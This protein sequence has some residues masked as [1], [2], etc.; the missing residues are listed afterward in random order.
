M[1]NSP[2]RAR[3]DSCT[4]S[5]T[6]HHSP[7]PK[8]TMSTTHSTFTSRAS[9]CVP[10]RFSLARTRIHSLV[11]VPPLPLVLQPFRDVKLNP[12]WQVVSQLHNTTITSAPSPLQPPRSPSCPACALPTLASPP[13]ATSPPVTTPSRPARPLR[14]TTSEVPVTYTDVTRLVPTIHAP[15]S[16]DRPLDLIVHVGVGLAGTLTLE[17]RGRRWGYE[18]EDAEGKLCGIGEG[19]MRGAAAEEWGKVV[20][21]GAEGDEEVRTVVRGEVVQ[22]WVRDRGLERLVISED[23]GKQCSTSRMIGGRRSSHA[24][25]ALACALPNADFARDC[26]ATSFLRPVPMRVHHLQL[27]RHRQTQRSLLGP[28]GDPSPVHTCPCVCLQPLLR[29]PFGPP[30]ARAQARL[31]TRLIPTAGSTSLIPSQS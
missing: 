24:C 28:A 20:E 12:S 25:S 10:I 30:S 6:C 7:Q 26:V 1:V 15:P 9:A 11:S 3:L 4:W 5:Q 23:A 21:T 2:T 19:G 29:P 13:A 16:G 17:Q 22:D 14:L 31:L 27:H 8:L 18:A